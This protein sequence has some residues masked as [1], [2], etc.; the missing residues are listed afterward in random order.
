MHRI[1]GPGATVDNKFTEGDPVGGIQATVVTDDWL[2]DIQEEVM[3]V[4]SAGGVTPVK[5]TQDQLLQSL[6][7]LLQVQKATAFIAA[8]TATALTLTPSPAISAYAANQRFTVKFPVNSGLNPTLNVSAKGAKNLKQYDASGAK[9]AAAFAA[10]QVGDVF[11]DG[12]DFVLLDPLRGNS[13][14]TEAVLGSVKIATQTQVNT[15]TDDTAAI[16]PL[17][18]ATLRAASTIASSPATMTAAGLITLPHGF[19]TVP[20]SLVIEIIN[21]VADVGYVPGEIVEISASGSGDGGTSSVSSPNATW[22]DATNAYLRVAALPTNITN[23]TNG[24]QSAITFARW[25][26]VLRAIK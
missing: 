22:K 10:D 18:L 24:I 1:D 26:I 19:G 12:T 14:A 5:G 15:G 11:Y 7:K 25:Q 20:S 3:S 6:Y 21:L 23:K 4:L 13:Q 16:T 9:V 8:G 17:K 2:N